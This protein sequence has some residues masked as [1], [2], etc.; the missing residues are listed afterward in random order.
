VT[1]Q[2]KP[3]QVPAIAAPEYQPMLTDQAETGPEPMLEFV[4]LARMKRAGIENRFII[5]SP[6]SETRGTPDRGMLRLL[7]QAHRY[8]EM[9]FA[10]QGRTMSD[11]AR[12]SGVGR[13]Y[14]CRMIRLGFLAPDVVKA[15][16][17]NRH[18][19]QLTAKRLSL[20]TKLPRAWEDQVSALGIT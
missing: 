3:S 16:L 11:L 1:I 2:V 10:S 9:M 15:V 19:P 17:T 5:D 8:R 6:N 13:P 4:V 14:F 7:V 18:P 20:R 12:E